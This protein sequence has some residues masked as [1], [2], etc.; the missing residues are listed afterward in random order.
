MRQM[1]LAHQAEFQPYSKK[2]RREQFLD[3]MD[4][5]MPWAA[6]VGVIEPHYLKGETGRNPV[7]LD[8]ML[9]RFTFCSS[10]S[11]HP[12]PAGTKYADRQPQS[13]NFRQ[14]SGESGYGIL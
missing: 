8:I 2:T 7:G 5:V 14:L 1:T 4:T 6:L 10:Q 9:R 3:E 13:S 11:L 12:T